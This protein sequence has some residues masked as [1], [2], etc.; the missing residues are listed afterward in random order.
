MSYITKSF[1]ASTE[2]IHTE[3]IKSVDFQSL[4]FTLV[5]LIFIT[6]NYL[7]KAIF[8]CLVSESKCYLL[9]FMKRL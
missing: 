7:L 4:K 1:P 2:V 8:C 6:T 9:L 5:I 3:Y